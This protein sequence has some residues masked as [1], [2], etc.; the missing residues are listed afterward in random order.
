MP[1]SLIGRAAEMLDASG[2][3]LWMRTEAGDELRPA[4]AHGYDPQM[5]ARYEFEASQGFVWTEPHADALT[6][7]Q[8]A[9]PMSGHHWLTASADEEAQAKAA[10][11]QFVR[12][13]G[14]APGP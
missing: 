6:L 10:G 9:D 1:A 2:L 8:Y 11:F 14:Y 12:V 13:E 3:V 7:K 5:V 4:V